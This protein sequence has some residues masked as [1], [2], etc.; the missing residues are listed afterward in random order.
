MAFIKYT[1]KGRSHAPRA[2]IAQSGRLSFS[3][4]TR[5]RYDLDS[6][7]HCVLYY[8]PDTRR[9]A[10][11][12]TGDSSAEGAIT[13]R[14]RPTGADVSAKSFIDYFDMGVSETTTYDV[15]RDPETG[16]LVIDL[17]RGRRRN[18]R[19]KSARA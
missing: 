16:W 5:K 10:V 18:P 8:D 1:A 6:Y 15:V 2:T 13:L 14:H 11:E 17:N 4:G 7:T 19:A 12:L 9:V 3:D